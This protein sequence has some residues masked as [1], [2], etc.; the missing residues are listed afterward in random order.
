VPPL[1]VGHDAGFYAGSIRDRIR[2]HERALAGLRQLET[3]AGTI[4]LIIGPGVAFSA[5]ELFDARLLSPELAA[6]LEDAGISSP[7]QLGI[8]LR[9]CCGSGLERLGV[10]EHGAIWQVS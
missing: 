3:L 8:R 9:R 5:R 4:A 2:A 1:G 6:A 7:R 10:D